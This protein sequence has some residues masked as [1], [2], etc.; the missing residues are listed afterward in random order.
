MPPLV[1]TLAQGEYL[2]APR[3]SFATHGNGEEINL[4]LVTRQLL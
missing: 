4:V 2:G 1:R 3:R